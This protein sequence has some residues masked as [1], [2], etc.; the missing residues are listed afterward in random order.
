MLLVLALPGSAGVADAESL[1]EEVVLCV[2]L[3]GCFGFQGPDNLEPASR[4]GGIVRK[5]LSCM[6]CILVGTLLFVLEF[7]AGRPS[8]IPEFRDVFVSCLAGL[9]ALCWAVKESGALFP[10]SESS[11]EEIDRTLLLRRS[12]FDITLVLV[13]L[14]AFVLRLEILVKL[15]V[16]HGDDA[17]PALMFAQEN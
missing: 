11:S 6:P 13:C 9:R 2:L 17:R 12:E 8:A 16:S 3:L 4:G 5:L 10:S 15:L 1:R 14:D 7:A